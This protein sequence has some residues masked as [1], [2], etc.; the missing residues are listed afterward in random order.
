MN[1]CE[2]TAVQRLAATV[3]MMKLL[4]LTVAALGVSGGLA[5]LTSNPDGCVTDFDAAAGVDYF[6]DKAVINFAETFSVEYFPTYKVLTTTDGFSNSTY[7][8]YQCGTPVPT[9]DDTLGVPV[10]QYISVPVTNVATGT[11]D[12][13]PRIEVQH[14]LVDCL[15]VCRCAVAYVQSSLFLCTGRLKYNS[16]CHRRRT[17]GR[18]ILA[19]VELK[20]APTRHPRQT[21]PELPSMLT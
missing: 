12:H 7:V 17:P 2:R 11:P 1:C 21:A 9:L 18:S 15:I 3:S 10:Q 16:V 20:R 6:P 8:L 4:S 5:Q 19:R 13:I 14:A